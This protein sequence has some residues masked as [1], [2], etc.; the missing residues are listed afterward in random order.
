[1]GSIPAQAGE[2]RFS[3]GAGAGSRVHPRAGGG[4]LAARSVII[5]DDGSIPAQAGEPR[6]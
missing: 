6:D 1:M 3:F 4:S 5:G 2:P